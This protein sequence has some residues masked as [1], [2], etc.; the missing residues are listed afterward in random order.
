M[1]GLNKVLLIGRLGKDPEVRYTNGGTAVAKFDLAT[2]E[3]YKDKDGKKQTKT[4]WH[5]CICFGKLGEVIGEYLKK[6]KQV[7]V[8]GKLQTRS[9]EDKEGVKRYTTEV[10]INNMVMLGDSQGKDSHE[11]QS[12]SGEDDIPF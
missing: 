3:S 2:D 9:W 8:E 5:R 6:G 1:S 4:E 12:F 11:N 10:N 7:Y